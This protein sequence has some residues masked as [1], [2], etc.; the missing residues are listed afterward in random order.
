MQPI[1]HIETPYGEKFAVPRQPGLAEAAEGQIV[2]EP[3]FSGPD[4]IRGIEGFSHLWL[5]F[6]F[7][8]TAHRGWRPLVRPPRLGGDQKVG[9]FASRS[10]HRPNGL[11]LSVVR[12]ISVEG[13]GQAVRLR[14]GGV[15]LVTGT[16]IYDIKPYLPFADAVPDASGGYAEAAPAILSVTWLPDARKAAEQVKQHNFVTLVEQVL[17]QDPRP[18][19][20][21]GEISERIYGVQLWD[22]NVRFQF[23]ADGGV[24]VVAV[25]PIERL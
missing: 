3:D 4:W 9:V 8:Q 21:R 5:I 16:P 1:A 22:R 12:L 13:E 18:A 10:T 20:R 23:G 25:E 6:G 11:G 15:D 19:Y 7:H 2:F 17:G 24:R 14:V